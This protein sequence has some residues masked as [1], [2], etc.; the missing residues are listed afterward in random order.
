MTHPPSLRWLILAGVWL[1][2]AMF[3]GL[4][5][6]KLYFAIDVGIRTGAPFSVSVSDASTG[7]VRSR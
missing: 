2:Y 1:I 6:S 7:V 3:G 4:L 5:G